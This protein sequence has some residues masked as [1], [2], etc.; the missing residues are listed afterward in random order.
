MT[1][2]KRSNI[3]KNNGINIICTH[4]KNKAQTKNINV[5]SKKT[6]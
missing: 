6:S 1:M 4:K 2:K 5:K 3:K